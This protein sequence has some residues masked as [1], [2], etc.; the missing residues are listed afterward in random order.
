MK[1]ARSGKTIHRDHCPK[2]RN[3]VHWEWADYCVDELH[4]FMEM[5]SFPWLKLC[6]T[7]FSGDATD[8]VVR[9]MDDLAGKL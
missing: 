5:V 4:M 7:C 2:A 6:Q 1:R 3:A 9:L 8:N